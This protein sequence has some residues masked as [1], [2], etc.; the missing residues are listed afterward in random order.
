[1]LLE[2][3]RPSARVPQEDAESYWDVAMAWAEPKYTKRKVNWAGEMLSKQD[4]ISLEDHL[5]MTAIINNWRSSHN[6]PLN[7]FH[8]GLKRRATDICASA[9]TAQ[10]IKRLASIDLKLT[11]F[12]TMTLGQMQDVGGCRAI[13][14]TIDQVDNLVELYKRGDLKHTLYEIDDYILEPKDS[15]YRGIHLKWKYLSDKSKK[16]N[17]LRIEMQLRSRL[18]HVWATAVETVGTLLSMS[19]KSSQGDEDWQRFF[20]LMSCAFAIREGTDL[21]PNCP[22]G[23]GNLRKEIRAYAKKLDVLSKLKMYAGSL[24]IV[25]RSLDRGGHYYLMELDT[26]NL[27]VTTTVYK[28]NQ[29]QLANVAYIKKEEASRNRPGFEVVLVSVDSLKSL[30][31]AYPNYFLD[32]KI[33]RELVDE[34]IRSSSAIVGGKRTMAQQLQLL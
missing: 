16:Y 32:T 28:A 14:E 2:A 24:D 25:T 7:T 18:Q 19:L 27:N 5:Q 12:K 8:I 4:D 31:S 6:F 17:G 1:M 23:W 33:F 30:R 22:T 10:R 3:S 15:G 26:G 34:T 13:L 20:A 21:I 9:I 11:R 29:S